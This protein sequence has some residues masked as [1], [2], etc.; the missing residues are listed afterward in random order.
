MLSTGMHPKVLSDP[1]YGL[2]FNDN[3]YEW[4]RPKTHKVVKGAWSKAVKE[5]NVLNTLRKMQGCSRQWYWQL[6]KAAGERAGI[7]GLCCNQ[8]RHTF[9]VNL[10][11]LEYNPYDIAFK[12]ATDFKTAYGFYMTGM[13]EGKSLPKEDKKFLKWLMEA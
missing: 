2:T 5:G 7:K 3:Y 8:S 4:N 1:A 6:L 12:S 11:R 13:G 9:F 10:A